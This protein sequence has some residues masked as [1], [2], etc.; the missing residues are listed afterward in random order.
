MDFGDDTCKTDERIKEVL[1]P[2]F[3]ISQYKGKLEA[4]G[5]L[6]VPPFRVPRVAGLCVACW[7]L[8]EVR[9][10][11]EGVFATQTSSRTL[12]FSVLDRVDPHDIEVMEVSIR[13]KCWVLAIL[14]FSSNTLA[15][16]VYLLY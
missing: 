10:S 15:V 8:R 3:P 2:V 5:P 1:V 11:Q 6:C 4:L 9:A 12:G 7:E 14:V 13:S 16:C